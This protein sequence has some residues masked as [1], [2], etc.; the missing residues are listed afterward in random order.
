M[1]LPIESRLQSP[2]NQMVELGVPV[3]IAKAVSQMLALP[4]AK[5]ASR[6][7]VGKS[8]AEARSMLCGDMSAML[9]V[10]G[11]TPGG[12]GG[13][14]PGA[15]STPGGGCFA[16]GTPILMADDSYLPIEDV[17]VGALV[18]SFDFGTEEVV[19][20]EVAGIFPQEYRDD[21]VTLSFDTFDIVCTDC[22][23]YWT[24]EAGWASVDPVK[25]QDKYDLEVA[26][27]EVGMQCLEASS[28]WV[29]LTEIGDAPAQD[30][31][32]LEVAGHHNY[33]ASG[34]LVHNKQG[35]SEDD[36]PEEPEDDLQL[37]T[38]TV[39]LAYAVARN[40]GVPQER[41]MMMAMYAHTR[42]L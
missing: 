38:D 28:E 29:S 14:T 36:E 26:Q 27:L 13:S 40:M 11:P 41:A 39:K 3:R 8:V 2:F 42:L 25:T 22:H 10:A 21:W 35:M 19:P 7:V 16:E 4:G 34:I 18:A 15:G 31:Y 33:F 30:T 32:N 37:A 9:K 24:R 20:A 1:K 6:V 17:G 23:P 12:G 5:T